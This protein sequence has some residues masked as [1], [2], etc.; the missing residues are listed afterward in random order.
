[1]KTEMSA[2]KGFKRHDGSDYYYHLVDVTLLLI[3]AGIRDEAT[4]TSSVLHDFPED[5]E[6]ITPE[7]VKHMFGQEVAETV[8]P[9]T[10]QDNVDY[11]DLNN[12]KEYYRPILENWRSSLVKAAD[13]MHNFSTLGDA[14]SEKKIRKV[15]EAQEVYIPFLREARNKYPRFASFF[16]L[17]KFAI[18]PI[19]REMEERYAVE[20]AL[21]LQIKVMQD[22]VKR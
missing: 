5:V 19:V 9:L 4:L 16:Y 17:A 14:S 12:L 8:K 20:G 10:K 13:I 21:R 7:T 18:E 15:E 6:G 3:N 11:K 22:E 1:M 2:E